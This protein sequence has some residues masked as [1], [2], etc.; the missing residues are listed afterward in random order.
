MLRSYCLSGLSVA[1]LAASAVAWAD[2]DRYRDED[3][4]GRAVRY[5][6]D[7]RYGREDHAWARVVRV[8]PI[9]RRVR[10]SE[11]VRE[12]WDEVEYR[13]D[14]PLSS[15][16]I[17]GTLIGAAIGGALGNQVGH[18]RGRDAAKIAGALLGG[19]IAYN[20]SK[21]H[22]AYDGRYRRNERMVERCDLRYRDDW[23][24]RIDGY[25]VTYEYDG[26]R[27]TTWM[28]YDPG[29]RIRVRVDVTPVSG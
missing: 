23:V 27:R 17:G 15:R 14:G 1:L 10:V 6:A 16:H 3:Q 9:R 21:E 11:P 12:C 29:E 28:S 20:V 8:E 5:E 19:A 13:P 24:E 2:H 7:D 4:Y 25:D 18:G 26:Q 22:Q